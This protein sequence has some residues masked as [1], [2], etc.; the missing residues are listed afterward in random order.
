MNPQRLLCIFLLTLPAFLFSLD[1]GTAV[2]DQIKAPLT[3]PAAMGVGNSAGLGYRQSYTEDGRINDFD[4]I[5][6]TGPLAYSYLKYPSGE[7]HLLSGG[8]RLAQ[9]LYAGTS[10][11]WVRE[12]HWNRDFGLSLLY[13]P[14]PWLSLALKG[15]DLTGSPCSITGIGFRPLLFQQAL[16]SRLNIWTE[17][18]W[19]RSGYRTL[20]GGLSLEPV[21][22]IKLSGSYNFNDETVSLSAALA[23]G[24]LET[25]TSATGSG[26]ETFHQGD[27]H[28]YSTFKKQRSLIDTG[29]RKALIYDMAQVITDSPGPGY[30]PGMS[31]KGTRSLMDFIRDMEQI[32]Q[33]NSIKA[34]VFRN[35]DFQTSFANLLEIETLLQEVRAS[36][37]KIYFFYDS[38]G[39]FPYTLAAAA[40]DGIY[41]SPAGSVNLRGFSTSR[42]YLK[43]F[44]SDWGILFQNFQSHPHKTAFNNLSES[45]MTDQERA[46]LEN[47]FQGLHSEQLRMIG[48]RGVDKFKVTPEEILNTGPFIFADRALELGMVDALYYED[49]FL[50]FMSREK[51]SLTPYSLSAGR[52]T[53]EW[54]GSGK[55]LIAVI[56][57]QGNIH[58]GTGI[59]G[60]SIGSDSMAKAVQRARNNPLVKAIIL[61]INSGGGSSL[62]SDLIAREVGLC[63]S[64]ENSKPVIVSM[65]GSAASGGYYIAVPA[66]YIIAS[67]GSITGS[68]GVVSVFPDISGLLEKLRIGTDT[69]KT[70]RGADTGTPLRPFSENETKQME[71][72]I[73][74]VY[75]K[76][77]RLVTENRPIQ[78]EDMNELAQ[79]RIWTGSQAV[80]NGLADQTGGL[81][82]A[83]AYAKEAIGAKKGIR[84][85]E[86]VPG[87]RLGF[88]ERAFPRMGSPEKS[89]SGIL[90]E[91]LE[92]LLGF[93]KKLESF[94][95]GEAL[96]LMPYSPEELKVNARP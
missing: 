52:M 58:S 31:W 55:P 89:S 47:L 73:R 66:D 74:A 21:Q 9:G 8:L 84:V 61:R 3:N 29:F 75:E 20:T 62:A 16:I 90:P 79:G 95:A 36:G 35:Q 25:G 38:L 49:Q 82:E 83:L 23:L 10:L 54:D 81:T 57:A 56:Y 63:G 68:I 34:L 59:S 86:M 44:L 96:Y 93:Y 48:Q 24:N 88:M 64:G 26:Q 18:R 94:P 15:E 6:S 85:L 87:R 92:Q 77:T 65:G 53:Y 45:S 51:L 46:S 22:G 41:L 71:E 32:K 78:E 14:L 28:V 67:P 42:F 17:A 11:G 69:V 30:L 33:E 43:D 1:N 4:I 72:Y 60:Q 19:D 76:F 7:K 70:A 37:K 40:G 27:M 5:F 39:N 2:E 50:N 80:D 13:R 12:N 91:D